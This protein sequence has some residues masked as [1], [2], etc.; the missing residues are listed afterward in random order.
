MQATTIEAILEHYCTALPLHARRLCL[1][2]AFVMF[3]VFGSGAET[4]PVLLIE[5]F[6]TL[7][8]NPILH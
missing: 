6:V 8:Q 4:L 7:P 2:V 3:L 1:V 5:I